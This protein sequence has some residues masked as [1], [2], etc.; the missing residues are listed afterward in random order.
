MAVA[1]FLAAAG[2]ASA[3]TIGISGSTLVFGA[4]DDEQLALSGATSGTDLFLDGATFEIVT[5]GCVANGANGV[6]CALAGFST[7]TVVGSNLDDAIALGQIFGLD[8]FVA[9]RDGDDIVVG[10]HGNDTITGGN[11]D[12]T[13]IGGGGLD[14][15]FGGLG[16]NLLIGGGPTGDVDPPDPV[17]LPHLQTVPEPATMMLMSLGLGVSAVRRRRPWLG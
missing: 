13:L 14:R 1:V 12:D 15:L 3:G 4:D 8:V 17:A 9:A 2:S 10:G 16:N 5:P 11:G 7:L 6:R